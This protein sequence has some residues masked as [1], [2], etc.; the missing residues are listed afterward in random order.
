ML[1]ETNPSVTYYTM[2][3]LSSLLLSRLLFHY[4]PVDGTRRLA[5]AI[6]LIFLKKIRKKLDLINVFATG[7]SKRFLIHS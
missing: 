6:Y 1:L 3:T 5:T 7:D 2:A 4:L